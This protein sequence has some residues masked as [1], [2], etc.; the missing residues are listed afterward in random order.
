M[1]PNASSPT[2]SSPADRQHPT[3]EH[4]R[5]AAG[6]RRV[7]GPWKTWGPYVSERA[8]GTVRE[9]YSENG[10]AWR[11]FPFDHARSRAYRWNEDGLAAVCDIGQRLCFGLALWN[12]NDPIL[13]ERIFGLSG[14][15]GNHAEDAKEEWTYLDATPTG[16]L[17]RWRYRYPQAAFPYQELRDENARRDHH[18]PEF[19]L[20]DTG[21]FDDSRYWIVTVDYAKAGPED[22]CVRISITNAGP[23]TATIDV[24]PSLWFRNTWSWGRDDRVPSLWADDSAQDHL[25]RAE[26]HSLGR[27]QWLGRPAEASA[28][29]LLEPVELLFC[30]NESNE[31]LL[32]GAEDSPAYPKDGIGDHVVTGAATINPARTGT[33]AAAHYRLRV[34]AGATVVLQQRLRAE[35]AD[36]GADPFGPGFARTFTDRA[37][38]ADQFFANVLGPNVALDSERGRIVRQAMAGMVW[39]KQFYHFDVERWLEG[40]PSSPPPPP[41]RQAGRNQQWSHLN[42]IDVISMPDKWEYPWY[43]AWDLA[44]H[45]VTLARIDP[46]F[47]KHQLTLLCREWYMHPNGQLPAYEWAFGDVNP[48]V[49]A[50][51][52]LRVFELD[53]GDD[54]DFLESLFHKLLLNFTWWV[55]RKDA[56]GNN[57]FEGGFLG[58]DNI[59]P[60]NRSEEVP[61]GGALEQ[62]D[63]SAWMAM[64][65]LN[66]LDI[67]LILADHRSVY[68]DVATKFLEHFAGIAVAMNDGGLWD[69]ALGFYRDRFMADDGTEVPIPVVSMVGLVPL[70]A[71][72]D[73]TEERLA[74]HPD[75]AKRVSWFRRN[76][77]R[78][79]APV[80]AGRR[81]SIVDPDRLATVLSAV[82]DE[83]QL[84]SPFGIRSLSKAHG[85]QPVVVDLGGRRHTLGYEPGESQSGA[86]GGNSNWRGP[87]WFPLNFLA[88]ES[89]RRFGDILGDEATVE[90]P[91]GSGRTMPLAA[92]ADDLAERLIGLFLPGADGHR[93]A[94]P[95]PPPFADDP[96]WA[97][98]VRFNEYF[99]G[100]TGLGLGAGHQTGWTGLV[101][102][103]ILDRA[104]DD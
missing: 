7:A 85:H 82:L 45:C 88:I 3:V 103:L 55:N 58:L 9:D 74:R 1:E 14:K 36:D 46:D 68:E 8:W 71:V 83:D 100:D 48:P 32:W 47:A 27:F 25:V 80:N 60:F 42:N 77:P 2:V 39:T 84:L 75:F 92:V 20:V 62:S 35:D 12:G 54:L 26:H 24:L 22:L 91:T 16:S 37:T 104:T 49:H 30:D 78:Q 97:D 43:A 51:A 38:E 52:A 57:L 65:C 93:P 28:T 34:E 29:T 41:S 5:I 95:T 33:K 50:W 40:D 96:W 90:H 11:S 23:E 70:F 18:D 44:F 15:E 31:A 6:G 72:S 61:A 59:G 13:K 19:E 4:E 64:Y 76:K 79:A 73:L 67:A 10:D 94:T 56:D 63:G 98:E 53:G 101:A 81:L 86:F 99:H 69:P 89:L 17:M 87:V 66:M 21:V 102:D